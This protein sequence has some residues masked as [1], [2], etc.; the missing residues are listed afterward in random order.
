MTLGEAARAV[1]VS[2]ATISKA[3]ANGRISYVEKTPAGYQIDPA[4]L[5]RVFPPKRLI[6]P[7]SEHVETP[8]NTAATPSLEVQLLRQ[9]IEDLRADRD[10]WRDQAQRLLLAAPT[11]APAPT[12]KPKKSGWFGF[13]KSGDDK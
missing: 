9:Q 6:P 5:F 4:E 7:V 3:L 11:Q 10:A 13:G 8:V 1:S 12:G 2:K